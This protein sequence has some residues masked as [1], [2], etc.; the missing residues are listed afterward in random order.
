MFH[1]IQ[2]NDLPLEGKCYKGELRT[3]LFGLRAADDPRFVPPVTFSVNVKLDGPDVVVEG[4]VRAR[5]ELECARCGKW[6][7]YD[8]EMENYYSMEPRD[9]A[10]TLDLTEQIREDILLSLPGYPRC[11]DS[12]VESR[13]CPAEGQFAAESEFAPLEPA[14][15]VE[16]ERRDVWGAL[17]KIHPS[18]GA[19]AR[20]KK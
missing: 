8:V 18:D 14:E 2:I 19:P 3:D 13:T 17:D 20:P 5:F 15:T 10:A 6:L 11:E 9:G 16:P 12:N 4:W 1:N 7:P